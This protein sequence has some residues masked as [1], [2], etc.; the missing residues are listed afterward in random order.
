MT[1]LPIP[2]T[3]FKTKASITNQAAIVTIHNK[4]ALALSAGR[5]SFIIRV[6][7]ELL[8][9]PAAPVMPPPNATIHKTARNRASRNDDFP[10]VPNL[11]PSWLWTLDARNWMFLNGHLWRLPLSAWRNLAGNLRR[12]LLKFFD[13]LTKA[14][15]LAKSPYKPFRPKYL[16]ASI[17]GTFHKIQQKTLL[18]VSQNKTVERSM[19]ARRLRHAGSGRGAMSGA[20]TLPGSRDAATTVVR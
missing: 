16:L 19:I 20:I 13:P 17:A 12:T 7:D 11:C 18:L 4:V 5:R 3:E 10:H 8:V 1:S 9:D 2:K 15:Q 14:L 6:L